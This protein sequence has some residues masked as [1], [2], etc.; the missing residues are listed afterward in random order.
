MLRQHFGTALSI[1]RQYNP[2]QAAISTITNAMHPN[3][4]KIDLFQLLDFVFFQR[5]RMTASDYLCS[6]GTAIA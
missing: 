5:H 1:S 4:H 6:I 3:H 2:D